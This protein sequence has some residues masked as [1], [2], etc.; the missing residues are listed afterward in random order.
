MVSGRVRAKASLRAL[1]RLVASSAI[2]LRKAWAPR[3]SKR[4]LAPGRVAH[5]GQKV[6]PGKS[7]WPMRMST[8]VNQNAGWIRAWLYLVGNV[9]NGA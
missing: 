1:C 4:G 3:D 8:I 5:L 7:G 6:C 2:L 9:V